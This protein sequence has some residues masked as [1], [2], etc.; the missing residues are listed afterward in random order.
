MQR[1]FNSRPINT[2]L[3]L[4]RFF[5]VAYFMKRKSIRNFPCML[6][7]SPIEPLLNFLNLLKK[8]KN[9]SFSTFFRQLKISTRGSVTE[10]S[11]RYITQ[12]KVVS[13][14]SSYFLNKQNNIACTATQKYIIKRCDV[15]AASP[16]LLS[17]LFSCNEF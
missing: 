4:S 17:T 5:R 13:V 9:S 10:Q 14:Y 3:V 12:E 1:C 6:V 8:C 15:A 2:T 16:R 7:L 11:A